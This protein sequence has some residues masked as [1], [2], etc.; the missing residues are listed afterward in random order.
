MDERL[1]AQ[2]DSPVKDITR[3]VYTPLN[4]DQEKDMLKVKDLAN[5]LHALLEI[6]HDKYPN[7]RR[8]L[9]FSKTKLEE[10]SM[11]AVKGITTSLA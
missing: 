10:C 6:S 5:H 2:Q 7:S 4:P 11:W 8:E 3:K 1:F 9:S